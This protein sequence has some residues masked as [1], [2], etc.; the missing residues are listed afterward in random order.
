MPG[1]TVVL[2]HGAFADASGFAGVIRG[3][4][5]EAQHGARPAEP[6]AKR[7]AL[8]RQRRRQRGQGHR[9]PGRA[10]RHSYGGAV[11]TQ[12]SAGLAERDRPGLS[13]GVRAGGGRE[14]RA[15]SSL[16]RRPCSPRRPPRPP[17]TRPA[18]RAVPTCTSRRTGSGRRSAPT[19]RWTWPMS[20]RRDPAPALGRGAQRERHRG[21]LEDKLSWFLVSEHDNAISPDA[22]RFMAQRMG[23]TTDTI[24]GS[25]TA[26]IAKA[27]RRSHV[28]PAGAAVTS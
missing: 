21:G 11:I 27:G 18:P 19:C 7:S 20:C 3:A 14:L 1:P 12:V 5:S 2:V 17:T 24:D 22:E 8:R 6:V 26:F 16:R 10:G 4:H 9:R 25:H 13:R 15:C 28:H 23:A